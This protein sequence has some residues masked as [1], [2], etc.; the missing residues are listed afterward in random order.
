MGFSKRIG[1]RPSRGRAG[2][3]NSPGTGSPTARLPSR[4][5]RFLKAQFS[6]LREESTL[7]ESAG[8]THHS[9]KSQASPSSRGNDTSPDRGEGETVEVRI[10][11]S[12]SLKGLRRK[13]PQPIA[14]QGISE[15]GNSSG[16]PASTPTEAKPTT[17]ASPADQINPLVRVHSDKLGGVAGTH[18][19]A[20]A[21]GFL[22]LGNPGRGVRKTPTLAKEDTQEFSLSFDEVSSEEEVTDWKVPGESWAP[23]RRP[24]GRRRP[25]VL[26]GVAVIVE[27]AEQIFGDDG[28]LRANGFAISGAGI[29]EA[30]QDLKRHDSDGEW[31]ED[32]PPSLRHEVLVRSLEELKVTR[33]LGAGA[34]GRVNLSVHVPSGKQ[35]A[36]KV[37]NVYDEAKRTQ[38]LKELETLSSFAS[39]FLVRFIGAFYDGKGAVHIALE[40]MDCGALSDV[41][42]ARGPI[43]E[44]IVNHIAYHCLLGLQFL[45]RSRVLHRDLKSANILLSRDSKRAKLSDFGLAREVNEGVSKADTFVGTLAYMSP[46]RLHGSPYT[47]AS[48]I[49]GLGVSIAECLLGRYPFDRPQS[50]FDYIAVATSSEH[51]LPSGQ[52]SPECEDFVVKCTAVDPLRR[53]TCQ[54]LLKH[55][56]ITQTTRDLQVFGKWLDEVASEKRPSRSP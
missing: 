49:W 40:Y 16:S 39:R 5:P 11:R 18:R 42:S 47:Y 55:P 2:S 35:M 7:P 12:R 22:K 21:G 31:F 10:P 29:I 53:P 52:F 45:H 51:I 14:T 15:A 37:V 44:H 1:T 54:L 17:P 41:I 34:N 19:R 48:D 33:S 43:P 3:E 36:V 46:E 38:I 4:S 56:W 30:P 23:G 28:T 9:P 8:D 32:V 26:G 50:Y 13:K 27:D 25:P 20:D 24:A 6:L